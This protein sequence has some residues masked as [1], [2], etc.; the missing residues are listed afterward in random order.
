MP[1]SGN[2]SHPKGAEVRKADM[3]EKEAEVV[4]D[5]PQRP[6]MSCI[7][8]KQSPCRGINLMNIIC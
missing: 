4:E 3:L 1:K 2:P 8:D 6:K 7:Q 5:L